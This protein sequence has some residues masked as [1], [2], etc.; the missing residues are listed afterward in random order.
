MEHH[1]QNSPLFTDAQFAQSV[2]PINT[3]M[4]IEEAIAN[5]AYYTGSTLAHGATQSVVD[6]PS[7]LERAPS[8][9]DPYFTSGSA[10][11]ELALVREDE[12]FFLPRV[13]EPMDIDP[14]TDPEECKCLYFVS[15]IL[16]LNYPR[17]YPVDP[18]GDQL[19]DQDRDEDRD[20][21]EEEGDVDDE[22]EDVIM[23]DQTPSMLDLDAAENGGE[24]FLRRRKVFT[25]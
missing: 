17:N 10:D 18:I 21:D 16:Q 22:Q 23:E 20:D 4:D 9:T 13:E 11:V 19:T 8:P 7:F 15:T 25:H 5:E 3:P 2:A 1:A 24:L 14:D 6:D 12:A